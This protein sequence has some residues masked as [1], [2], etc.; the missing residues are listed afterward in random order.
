MVTKRQRQYCI[1]FRTATVCLCHSERESSL[2]KIGKKSFRNIFSQRPELIR[3]GYYGGGGGGG[4]FCKICTTGAS[5]IVHNI[6]LTKKL[7]PRIIK[8]FGE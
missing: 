5:Q 3:V 7:S 1:S 4:D 8:F 2:D 6:L